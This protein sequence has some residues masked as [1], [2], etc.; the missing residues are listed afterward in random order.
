MLEIVDER[1]GGSAAWL[2]TH[3]LSAEDLERLRERL[4]PG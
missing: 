2:S 4:G 1:H 3:G